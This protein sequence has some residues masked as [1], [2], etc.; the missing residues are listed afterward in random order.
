ME[1]LDFIVKDPHLG[2]HFSLCNLDQ[3]RQNGSSMNE[4]LECVI[5]NTDNYLDTFPAGMCIR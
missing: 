5:Y 1:S 3:L 4:V 2:I